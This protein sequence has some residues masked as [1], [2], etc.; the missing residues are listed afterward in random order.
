MVKHFV[1]YH[2]E[3]DRCYGGQES[4]LMTS[5]KIH[6]NSDEECL[7]KLLGHFLNEEEDV[8]EAIKEGHQAVQ[9]YIDIAGQE[10]GDGKDYIIVF[11]VTEDK[12]VFE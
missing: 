10:N 1:I 7:A 6:G 2:E 12:I 5:E 3:Y 8:E 11:D 9:D 4:P